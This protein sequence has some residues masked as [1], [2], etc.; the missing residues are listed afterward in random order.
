M[1]NFRFPLL[2]A[3]VLF[4][5]AGCQTGFRNYADPTSQESEKWISEAGSEA[6]R[7]RPVDKEFDPL[8]LRDVLMSQKARDIERNL[9]FE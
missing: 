8:G 4:L 6:R 2:I 5:S 3:A 1:P 9:G 7:G